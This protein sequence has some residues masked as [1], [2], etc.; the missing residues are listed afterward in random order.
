[1]D[2]ELEKLLNRVYHKEH[3][4]VGINELYRITKLQNKE[5]TK[6]YVSNWLKR[7][8]SKQQ[9][10]SK[11]VGKKVFK[12]IYS[13][14]F[15]SFQID[16]TFIPKYKK[17]NDGYYVLF[18]AININSRYAYE[19]HAKDK[20]ADTVINMLNKFLKNALEVHTIT[21]DSGSEFTNKKVMKWFEENEIFTYFVNGDSHK[22]G[23]INRFH[24]TLKEKLLNYF[25]E[26][27]TVKWIDVI[28][29]VIYN[30]NRTI[31]RGIGFT[32]LE[33]SKHL[34][35]SV[36][37]NNAKNKVSTIQTKEKD[38]FKVGDFCR[39]ENDKN[40][41]NKTQSKYSNEI[42]QIVKVGKFSLEV[43]NENG[44]T[45][46]VKKD[47]VIVVSKP[48]KIVKDTNIKKANEQ[49]K[50]DRRLKMQKL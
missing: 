46:S 18:T 24:R 1:M 47:L 30:Y 50:A 12:P 6:A 15:Y 35:Q 32:P 11:V 21:L 13:E 42:Y 17:Q 40:T 27:D 38:D 49:S 8:N 22:L 2:E 43:E 23:I 14:D 37:I 25:L 36:I 16:L 28:D 26:E 10:T 34:I 5:I 39:V 7:Q 19:Y 29:K 9:I 45:Y 4:Y 48:N 41:F 31:N 20:E 3:N 33:A 44:D